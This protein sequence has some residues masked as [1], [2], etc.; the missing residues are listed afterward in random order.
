VSGPDEPSGVLPGLDPIGWFIATTHQMLG[1]DKAAAVL[2]QSPGDRA[3][4]LICEHERG[5]SEETRQAVIRA[6]SPLLA[7]G[8]QEVDLRP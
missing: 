6:L 1:H 7:E 8:V 3:A 4:C 2:G 5:P